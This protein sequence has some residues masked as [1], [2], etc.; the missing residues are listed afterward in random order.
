M[1]YEVHGEER[2]ILLG[3]ALR[4]SSPFAAPC[5]AILF[6]SATALL[7]AA[8]SEA[9]SGGVVPVLRRTPLTE[10]E[11]ARVERDKAQ[12]YAAL[13]VSD[14]A[15]FQR[16]RKPFPGEW[17]AEHREFPQTVERYCAIDA[18]SRP[19]AERRVAVLQPLGSFSREQYKQLEVLREYAGIFF[20]ANARMDKPVSLVAD[21]TAVELTRQVSMGQRHGVYERQYDAFAILKQV[22][23]SRLPEDALVYVGVTAEDLFVGKL[24]YLFGLASLTDRTAVFGVCRFYPEFDGQVRK[25]EDDV[26]ILRRMLKILNHETAHI[27]GLRHCLFFRCT[28]NGCNSRSELDAAPI[29]L[30]PVCHR[31]LRW[32]LNWNA[33]KRYDELHSFY[34]RHGLQAEADWVAQRLKRWREV[35]S[36]E[37]EGRKVDDE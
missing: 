11:E 7:T 28:M 34:Q 15:G 33:E 3:S 26:Q 21:D 14:V 36:S 32:A 25:A 30:C 20:Q 16:L 24:N 35:E 23:A 6:W 4:P 18:H 17:L 8:E 10:A 12:V 2:R 13:H 5:A 31:K 9:G 1:V 27:F 37:R 22:L 19:T 29:H